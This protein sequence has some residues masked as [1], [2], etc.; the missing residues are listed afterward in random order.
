MHCGRPKSETH[1]EGGFLDA[2]FPYTKMF[3]N[4]FSAFLLLLVSSLPIQES[5]LVPI[6]L[7]LGLG[8]VFLRYDIDMTL[9]Q[10]YVN[11]LPLSTGSNIL[12]LDA[13]MKSGRVV[14]LGIDIIVE[15][16]NDVFKVE[17]I[18]FAVSGE[19]SKGEKTSHSIS[20]DGVEPCHSPD[21][22]LVADGS[23]DHA[24][25]ESDLDHAL[26]TDKDATETG[27]TGKL[28]GQW[29]AQEKLATE[30]VAGKV[31]TGSNASGEI[32]PP[33]HKKHHSKYV[34]K[35]LK[36]VAFVGGFAAFFALLAYLA[37]LVVRLFSKK[38]DYA[39]VADTEKVQVVDLQA[40]DKKEKS[41]LLSESAVEESLPSYE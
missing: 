16:R 5:F 28:V 9:H 17:Q 32:P 6:E 27:E 24:I 35:A 40:N 13:L 37:T 18:V 38:A 22:D 36:G 41:Q 10:L 12:I 30:T 1:S 4:L 3:S 8:E 29:V 21:D 25:T 23:A 20:E 14:E 34:R 15:E 2:I 31:E 33:E 39:V 11:K 19:S 26:A 7:G